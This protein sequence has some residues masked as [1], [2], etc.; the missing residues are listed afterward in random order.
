M[1][2]SPCS[3]AVLVNTTGASVALSTV[4]PGNNAQLRLNA[5]LSSLSIRA[6]EYLQRWKEVAQ[7][8]SKETAPIVTGKQIGRAHV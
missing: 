4:G 7:F 1:Y 3:Q 8:S 6:T 5:D 2:C